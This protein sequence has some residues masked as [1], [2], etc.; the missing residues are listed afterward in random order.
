MVCISKVECNGTSNI[1]RLNE[2]FLLRVELFEILL[3]YAA[4]GKRKFIGNELSF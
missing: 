4:L 3:C 2:F 1:I